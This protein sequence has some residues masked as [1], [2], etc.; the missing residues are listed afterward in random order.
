VPVDS[1]QVFVRGVVIAEAVSGDFESD[2]SKGV[3]QL[4]R[5]TE[6]ENSTICP[7]ASS[8]DA[9]ASSFD[10]NLSEASS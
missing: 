5:F 3:L 4:L 10:S 6:V 1:A 9:V 7:S 2:E 8:H